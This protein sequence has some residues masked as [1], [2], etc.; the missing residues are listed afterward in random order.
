MTQ[1]KSNQNLLLQAAAKGELEAVKTLIEEGGDPNIRNELG[2]TPLHWAVGGSHTGVANALL[3]AGADPN[4]KDNDGLTP[5][6]VVARKDGLEILDILL[7][8]G[9]DPNAKDN[10]GLTPTLV[11]SKR[12]HEEVASILTN[13][14]A[15]PQDTDYVTQT[16][17]FAAVLEDSQTSISLESTA[18]APKI[19]PVKSNKDLIAEAACNLIREN[20]EIPNIKRKLE[21]AR[22]KF[23]KAPDISEINVNEISKYKELL[24]KEVSKYKELFEKEVMHNHLNIERIT[25]EAHWS[26]THQLLYRAAFADHRELVKALIEEGT[27]CD[28]MKPVSFYYLQVNCQMTYNDLGYGEVPYFVLKHKK[29]TIEMS[30]LHCAALAGHVDVVNV[31]IEAAGDTLNKKTQPLDWSPL[32]CAARKGHADVANALIQAGADL[33]SKDKGNETPLCLAFRHCHEQAT[34]ILIQAGADTSAMPNIE[35]SCP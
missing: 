27:P 34:S 15:N 13:S 4:A 8:A 29:K 10:D 28:I 18:I 21:E 35:C 14:E 3:K 1:E 22:T 9:A 25:M 7:K 19:I 16:P 31:L 11:A 23:Q 20:K 5:L 17:S 24:E 12:G 2:Q 6:H 26:V 33:E 30:P 32:H